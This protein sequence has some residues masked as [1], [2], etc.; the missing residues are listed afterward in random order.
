MLGI[1][2]QWKIFP[3]NMPTSRRKKEKKKEE[4]AGYFCSLHISRSRFIG[5]YRTDPTQPDF[6]HT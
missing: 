4:D 5:A 6:S 1:S 3:L 2:P